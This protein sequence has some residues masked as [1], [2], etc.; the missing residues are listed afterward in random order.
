VDA[1][2]QGNAELRKA[3]TVLRAD[4]LEYDQTSDVAKAIGNARL[5]RG[6]NV[7]RAGAWSSS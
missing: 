7:T 3:D 1:V 5:N 6:G 2:V 4:R